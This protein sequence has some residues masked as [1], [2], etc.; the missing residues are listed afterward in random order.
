[1]KK[2]PLLSGLVGAGLVLT[3]LHP[4]AVA[5]SVF[6]DNFS[7]VKNGALLFNDPFSDGVPPPNAPNFANG[8]PASYSVLGTLDEA[9]GKVKLDTVGAAI[10]PGIGGPVFIE[11]GLLLTNIDPTNLALGLKNDDTFSVTGVFDLV[12]PGPNLESY[13]V[14]FADFATNVQGN[15]LLELA[16]RRG[17]D[18][19]ARVQFFR[20]DQIADTFT[21][22]AAVPLAPGHDQISLTLARTTL[23]NDEI[24]A[25]FFYIDGGVPGPTTTFIATS[26]I[27]NGENWTRAEFQFVTPAP[28]VEPGTLIFLGV[29]LAG[30]TSVAWRRHRR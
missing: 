30:L 1:M 4:A 8:T 22:I 13:G 2:A 18:G 5:S 26:D 17:G 21:S 7:V 19:M 27:F 14:R 16:V 28:V 15:D 6:I 29:G 3:L 24:T 25:S 20:L 11:R 23:A 9:G 10:I 12:V